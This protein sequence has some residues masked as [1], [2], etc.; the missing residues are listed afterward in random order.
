MLRQLKAMSIV[1]FTCL[2]LNA[3]AVKWDNTQSTGWPEGFLDIRI[4]SSMDGVA[5]AA[6]YRKTTA[7]VA[8]P[9][10]VSLHTWSG[11]YTQKDCG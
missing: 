6:V 9:L 1:F 2:I 11:N 8:K 10:V 5:Q 3:A 7:T 4:T